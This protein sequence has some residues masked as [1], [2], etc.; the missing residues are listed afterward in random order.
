MLK[1]TI[2]TIVSNQQN[3]I[4]VYYQLRFMADLL[5]SPLLAA[6]ELPLL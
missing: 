4:G 2:S 5:A 3:S 1:G 6:D